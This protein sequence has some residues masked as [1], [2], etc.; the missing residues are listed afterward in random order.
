M[1]HELRTILSEQGIEGPLA[2][3]IVDCIEAAA[4]TPEYRV[5][6]SY[7]SSDVLLSN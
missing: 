3:M 2:E 4:D 7:L 5:L 1:E 6:A